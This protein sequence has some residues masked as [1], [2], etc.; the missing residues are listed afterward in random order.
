L[1]STPS[2]VFDGSDVPY[3]A[4]QQL[5]FDGGGTELLVRRFDG[6]AWQDVV[7]PTAL[8][9]TNMNDKRRW[10]PRLRFDPQ[11]Q[12]FLAVCT[13]IERDTPLVYRVQA[14]ALEA[15]GPVEAPTPPNECDLAISPT[16]ELLLA[17]KFPTVYEV[18]RRAA[19]RWG[20]MSTLG[21]AASVFPSGFR[22]LFVG[23]DLHAAWNDNNV[24]HVAR[25]D[26]SKWNELPF[27]P[28]NPI[29]S[30]GVELALVNGLLTLA[31]PVN[32]L[33]KMKADI[34]HH[35]EGAWER[36]TPPLA[37]T[38]LSGEIDAY[39]LASRAGYTYLS[40]TTETTVGLYRLTAP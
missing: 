15:L 12:L 28:V 26:G 40:Y 3:V 19:G 9:V 17:F 27:A 23:N 14:G 32:H 35:R 37:T 16:G 11:G 2:I 33:D 8:K 39:S 24:V 7:P 38:G 10:R 25:F 20:P 4:L 36:D 29:N 13:E 5:N 22:L 18:W 34:Y 30:R 21:A 31:V 1:W 6:T